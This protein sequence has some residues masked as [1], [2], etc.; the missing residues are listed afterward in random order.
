MAGKKLLLFFFLFSLFSFLFALGKKDGQE[1]TPISNEWL[2]CVTQF[3]FSM[4][5][6]SQRISGEVVA[7]SLIKKLNDVSFRLRV[8]PEYAYYAGYAWRQSVNAAARAL[9]QK[10]DERSQLLYRGDPEWRYMKNIAKVNDEIDKLK[11]ELAKKEAQRP[12]VNNEPLFGLVKTNIDGV[13]PA[14]PKPG[15]ERR[16]CQNQKADAFLLGSVREFHGRLYLDLK[17]YGLYANGY[18]YEDDIIFS[19]DDSDGAVEEIASRLTSALSGNKP[20]VIIVKADPPETQVLINSSYAGRG[21]VDEREF[22]PGKITVAAAAEGYAPELVESD[23]AGGELTEI[24]FTLTPLLYTDVNINTPGFPGI[25]LYQGA[26]YVG[27]SP[28]NLRLPVDTMSYITAVDKEKQLAKIVF[29][30]PETPDQP[31]NLSMLIKPLQ[32]SRM[33]NKARSRYY[34]S[35]GATWIAAILAWSVNGI[36]LSH[37]DV[38]TRSPSEEFWDAT[39]R[40]YYVNTGSMIL[41]GGVAAYNIYQLTRYLYTSTQG[42]AKIAKQ[43]KK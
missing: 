31:T 37:N 2:L 5:P 7:R 19:I 21:T 13:F 41:F 32:G 12:V 16:F 11:E 1:V 26:L 15:T 40:W 4:I 25:P 29:N 20:A 18:I 23:L 28:L 10:Q 22:P 8:S 38:L 24:D 34:W 42:A 35:W 36:F 39:S 27:E 14:P 3:D 17:L 30:T 9:S 43:E 33:V 6:P